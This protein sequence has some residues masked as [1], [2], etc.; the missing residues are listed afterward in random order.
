MDYS[1]ETAKSLFF[2]VDGSKYH[3]W[4]DGMIKEYEN[5][6][7]DRATE[8]QWLKEL[9]NLRLKQYK[10]TSK[11]EYLRPIIDLYNR[12][13]LLDEIIK[14]K[15]KGSYINKIAIIELLIEAI[16]RNR[17]KIKNHEDY[18]NTI[19][20]NYNKLKEGNIPIKY[21]NNGLELRMKNIEEK[22]GVV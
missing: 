22:L 18:K 11:F 16:N 12:Y 14:V 3:L 8:S 5:Y 6:N 17:G 10:Q 4:H 21:L 20:E 9:T 19:I 15:F 7:I 2:S 13:D 1:L